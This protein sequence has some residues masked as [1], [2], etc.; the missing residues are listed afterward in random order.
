MLALLIELLVRSE[1]RMLE[2]GGYFED[3]VFGYD[4]SEGYTSL[5]NSAAKVRPYKER[6]SSPLASTSL[7]SAQ[8]TADDPRGRRGTPDG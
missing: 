8:A 3:G 1:S 5:E 2:D 6:R 4:F 7:G